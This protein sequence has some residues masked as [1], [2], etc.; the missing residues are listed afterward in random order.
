MKGTDLKRLFFK[1]LCFKKAGFRKIGIKAAS[2]LLCALMFLSI[3][4]FAEDA[5]PEAEIKLEVNGEIIN[6]EDQKPILINDRTYVPVRFLAEALGAEVDW[7]DT[8][9]VVIIKNYGI[10]GRDTIA[11]HYLRLGEN[12]MVVYGYRKDDTI[13]G[14]NTV[15]GAETSVSF[16]FPDDIYPIIVN[17]RTML[18]FRYVAELLGAQVYY[19]PTTGTAH[20]VK[21]D[22]GSGNYIGKLYR[23]PIY[24]IFST[25]IGDYF[26]DELNKWYVDPENEWGASFMNKSASEVKPNY[27]D[28]TLGDVTAWAGIDHLI[29]PEWRETDSQGHSTTAHKFTGNFD[30]ELG[31]YAPFYR[32]YLPNVDIY[33]PTRWEW[34]EKHFKRGGYRENQV[35]YDTTKYAD[36]NYQESL[37]EYNELVKNWGIKLDKDA[38]GLT[39]MAKEE[40]R[41]GNIHIFDE[42]TYRGISK[43]LINIWASS[44]GHLEGL[45]I[46]GKAFGVS[47][48]GGNAYYITFKN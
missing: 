15:K 46:E 14:N 31:C 34:Q 47:I 17:D 23:L 6:F 18:P 8:H 3:T 7:D 10:E 11:T 32:T 33:A 24:P 22:Y 1:K 20:C 25:V 9:K 35:I 37:K 13:P 36:R 28:G 38:I 21:R 2:L 30:N 12:K 27:F 41:I 39:N 29:H 40:D 48:V 42:Q 5:A 26:A 4:A 16:Y 44:P 19:D 45:C 43:G